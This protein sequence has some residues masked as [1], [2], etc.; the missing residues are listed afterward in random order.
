MQELVH[1][2][3]IEPNP[4]IQFGAD[5]IIGSIIFVILWIW[6]PLYSKEN[7]SKNS[8]NRLGI[9]LGF[10]VMSNYLVWVILEIISGTF[11]FK[12]HLPFHLCRFA[13]LA[14]PIV[15]IWKKER[16]FQ[17]L[18]FWGMSGMLQG[19]ITPDV[20]H[21]FPHF[22]YFRFFI[23]HNG[24]VLVLI[25]AIVV[26]GFRPSFKGLLDSFIALNLF[27]ILAAV[28]NLILDSNYFWI[29]A[30]PPTNSLLDYLGPW[31]WYILIAEFVA[32]LHYFLA[33]LPFYILN[34]KKR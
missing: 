17:V 16:L 2:Y 33:F 11:D 5:H 31:P 10:I 30:K 14:I 26:L 1:K 28:I 34:N 20:T 19:A 18:Y 6:L 24:M 29:C 15:M 23:G 4:F 21:G 3:M 8:Q 25:Y 13:N 22:H 12:L 9:I 7:L 32:L 27:L